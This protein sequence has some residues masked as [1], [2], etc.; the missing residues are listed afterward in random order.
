MNK[1]YFLRKLIF[2][3][4]FIFLFSHSILAQ[5]DINKNKTG[6]PTT[7]K[8]VGKLDGIGGIFVQY[9]D[10]LFRGGKVKDQQGVLNLKERGVTKII[11]I[12]K[13]KTIKKIAKKNGIKYYFV[14][15]EKSAGF[16]PKVYKKFIKQSS[17]GGDK[18]FLTGE[19]GKHRVGLLCAVFRIEHEKWEYAEAMREFIKLG[20][21]P[22]KDKTDMDSV[23]TII[24]K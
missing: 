23:K 11:S 10:R 24:T 19:G 4:I 20:G 17:S 16:T 8:S 6:K 5:L 12:Y 22:I 14:N 18:Y 9:S 2:F 21:D 15:Y 7:V 3:Q 1:K 13:D